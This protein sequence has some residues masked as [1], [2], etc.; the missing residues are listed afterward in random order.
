MFTGIIEEKGSVIA[1]RTG[2]QSS[3]LTIGASKVLKDIRLGD[4]ICTN[5]VCLTV[6]QFSSDSFTVEVMPE[7]LRKTN[8]NFL[9]NGSFVNLERAL[10][11]S[12]RIGGHLVSGHVD[13]TGS[14]QRIVTDG[15]AIRFQVS[16]EKGLLKYIIPQGSVALDGISLTVTET[17]DRTFGVS[18]IPHTRKETTLP[19]KKT[20][21]LVNIECDMIARYTEKLTR[22]NSQNNKIDLEFLTNHGYL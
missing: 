4:S 10:K 1:V 5:G 6:I 8:L 15:I 11:L 13:G 16:A 19:L 18:I 14:I 20:G 21:D 2:N 7:T 12:D 22:Y 9:K 3:E 17:F